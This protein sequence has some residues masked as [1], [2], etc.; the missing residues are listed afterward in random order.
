MSDPRAPRSHSPADPP[1]HA[2]PVAHPTASGKLSLNPLE[3]ELGGDLPC[4]VC[5]YNLRGLSIRAMCPECGTNVRA[6][7]LAVIDPRASELQP[8]RFPRLVA[9]GVVAWNAGAA[10][11]ALLAWLPQ[12]TDLASLLGIRVQPRPNVTLGLIIGLIISALGGLALVRPHARIKPWMSAAAAG[13]VLLYIPLIWSVWE[14]QRYATPRGP[15]HAP[16]G[17]LELAAFSALLIGAII[18]AQR[19]MARL[20]VA[21]SLVLRTGKVDRQTLYAVAGA[22]MVAALG[23]IILRL[24]PDSPAVL[25]EAARGIGVMLLAIGALLVTIGLLGSMLDSARIAQA[26]L[27]PRPT[28]RQVLTHGAPRPRS[29]IERI[30]DAPSAELSTLR[31][32]PPAQPPTTAATEPKA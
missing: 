26:I 31:P 21:R 17:G 12:V 32:T 19:P 1:Q 6:T 29:R 5:A 11:A 7:I 23:A 8:I 25:A 13:A 20:L 10:G 3:R 9:L 18:F 30:L 14:A 15:L 22:S 4:I 27:A 24:A 28:L 16:A 2:A